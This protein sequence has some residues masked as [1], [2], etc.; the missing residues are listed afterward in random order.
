M[1][2]NHTR[3]NRPALHT[4]PFP[5]AGTP[6]GPSPLRLVAAASVF[7]ADDA[8]RPLS[9]QLVR[10]HHAEVVHLGPHCRAHDV[11]RAA[12]QEDADA[13]IIASPH[14]GNAGYF[15]HLA[16]T[17]QAQGAGRLPVFV[18]A[19]DALTAHDYV[20]LEASGVCAVY[21]THTLSDPEITQMLARI[22]ARTQAIQEAAL[23]AHAQQASTWAWWPVPSSPPS[24]PLPQEHHSAD[25][26]DLAVARMLTKLEA[27]PG[28]STFHRL[29]RYSAKTPGTA[30]VIGLGG[31]CAAGKSALLDALLLR[32]LG[33]FP[34]MRIA[35][36]ALTPSRRSGGALLGD[37]QQMSAARSPR[38]YMRS[39]AT[40]R[41][42]T[43]TSAALQE[44]IEF[45]KT[46][47][48]DLVLVETAGAGPGD[49][50]IA[51]LVDV[52]VYVMPPDYGAASQLEQIEML[53]EAALVVL[54]KCDHPSAGDALHA[55]RQYWRDTHHAWALPDED[56]PVHPTIACH[57]NEPGLDRVFIDLCQR[58]RER[59]HEAFPQTPASIGLRTGIEISSGSYTSPCPLRF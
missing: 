36:L 56:I 32:F 25:D 21:R 2:I 35:V 27:A 4:A 15:R 1:A 23:P 55:T 57:G 29:R 51:Q 10:H 53:D 33:H 3:S 42:D 17:L 41:P 8:L 16:D 48:F 24:P 13:I 18:L 47:D 22:S 50:S 26:D 37:R 40:R 44:C 54:N 30:P 5:P 20:E 43:A 7:S 9:R 59:L 11:A 49:A 45:L 58:V 38:V 28:T 34:Q 14:P 12:V 52:P 39:M 6:A 46:G 19:G 31:P